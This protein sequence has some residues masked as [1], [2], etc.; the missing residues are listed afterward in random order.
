MMRTKLLAAAAALAIS[1]LQAAAQSNNPAWLDQ[2]KTE[3]AKAKAC[4]VTLFINIRESELAGR[5]LYEARVQC[6]DGRMFDA[7]RQEPDEHFSF[8]ACGTQVCEDTG[9]DQSNSG[10]S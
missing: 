9:S 2:L 1:I 4:D 3:I 5:R 6:A 10:K 8:E 7:S